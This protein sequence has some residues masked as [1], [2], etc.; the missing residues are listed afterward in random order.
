MCTELEKLTVL[1]VF[2]A[3]ITS[4]KIVPQERHL[5]IELYLNMVRFYSINREYQKSERVNMKRL[6]Y[7]PVHFDP[8]KK[9]FFFQKP[10]LPSPG[11]F[12]RKAPKCKKIHLVDGSHE[13]IFHC[14]TIMLNSQFHGLDSSAYHYFFYLNGDYTTYRLLF[15]CSGVQKEGLLYGSSSSIIYWKRSPFIVICK[16]PSQLVYPPFLLVT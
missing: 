4:R 11:K 5:F 1:K 6:H 12:V 13:S 15:V 10:R 14:F 2:D 9:H 16:T 3:K 8:N 7:F